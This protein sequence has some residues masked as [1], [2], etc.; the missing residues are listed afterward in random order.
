MS[1][2]WAPRSKWQFVTS[3]IHAN[4]EDITAMVRDA[5]P[6]TFKTMSR[7]VGEPF[8]E[9]QKLL[10]YDTGRERGGLRMSK[11]FAVSY[12]RSKYKGKTCYYFRWS[13]IEH[14][15]TEVS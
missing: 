10:N 13:A 5:T 3:C 15:F 11:D 6:V 1:T 14:I 4:G 9:Q 12:W 7:V 8:R 2:R